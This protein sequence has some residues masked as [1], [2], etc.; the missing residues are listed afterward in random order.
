MK[1]FHHVS[2]SWARVV[3][4]QERIFPTGRKSSW[5][6]G[7]G[8]FAM[9]R[10]SLNSAHA[11][12]ACDGTFDSLPFLARTKHASVLPNHRVESSLVSRYEFNRR[13]LCLSVDMQSSVITCLPVEQL[14][15]RAK[16]LAAKFEQ[17]G[18]R[19]Y[20]EEAICHD[21]YFSYSL[22]HFFTI[23]LFFLLLSPSSHFSNILSQSF[24][25]ILCL[26]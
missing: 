25:Y 16:S 15:S 10:R 1:R 23:S 11:V 13:Y 18:G 3:N 21:S 17:G 2:P 20:I 5:L 9:S 7:G 6:E 19:S 14:H 24:Y 26:P 4:E 12:S 22:L 8:S